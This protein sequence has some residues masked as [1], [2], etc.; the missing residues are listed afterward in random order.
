[1]T[2]N[3]TLLFQQNLDSFF[4]HDKDNSPGSVF[5]VL[6][7][8]QIKY[9]INNTINYVNVETFLIYTYILSLIFR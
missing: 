1:M 9:K 4:R 6:C 5:Y 8:R 2:V 3:R 7:N